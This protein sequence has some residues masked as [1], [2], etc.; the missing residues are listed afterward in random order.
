MEDPRITEIEDEEE[1]PKLV[2]AKKG[3]NKRAA[4]DDSLDAMITDSKAEPTEKLSKKQLYLAKKEEMK[5]K[6]EAAAGAADE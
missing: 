2:E 5:R 3:K 1:A 4:A 6:K